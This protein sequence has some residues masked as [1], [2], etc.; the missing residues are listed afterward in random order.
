MRRLQPKL[1]K[2]T[3]A[4]ADFRLSLA[5]SIVAMSNWKLT[6]ESPAS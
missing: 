3:K 2:K 4:I 6:I 5:D 1:M